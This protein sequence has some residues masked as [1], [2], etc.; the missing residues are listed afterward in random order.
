M[1]RD[2]RSHRGTLVADA[3]PAAVAALESVTEAAALLE[4][5]ALVHAVV[6]AVTQ[7]VMPLRTDAFSSPPS[8]LNTCASFLDVAR[9]RYYYL[10]L[11]SN[12]QCTSI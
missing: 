10:L 3:R 9:T 5:A 7:V 11:L 8:Q 1:C 4:A 2:P 6:V 12:K